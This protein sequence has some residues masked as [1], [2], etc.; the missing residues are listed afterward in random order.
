M[1]WDPTSRMEKDEDLQKMIRSN[2]ST[3]AWQLK[4]V[5]DVK[6]WDWEPT[7]ASQTQ[8]LIN[9]LDFHESFNKKK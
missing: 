1:F 3:Y 4:M 2:H 9:V 8:K 6:N 7:K 5:W